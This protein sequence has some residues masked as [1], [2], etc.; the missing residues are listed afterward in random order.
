MTMS[1]RLATTFSMGAGLA[2]IAGLTNPARAAADEA[3]VA[4]AV[5]AYRKAILT[6]DKAALEA[7]CAPQLSYGHSSGVIQNKE[8]F[9]AGTVNSKAV[10][11]SLEFSNTWNS[12]VGDN[13]ISRFIWTSESE[14]DGKLAQTK[15]G[16]MIVWVQQG[17]AWKILARQAYKL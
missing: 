16:V 12:V 4:R 8:E 5:E 3:S 6:K 17:G 2:L 1:R 11:K 10:T 14:T 13:A 7:L 15:I 9:V